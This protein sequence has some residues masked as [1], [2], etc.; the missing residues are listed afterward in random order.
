MDEAKMTSLSEQIARDMREGVFPKQSDSTKAE[1]RARLAYETF[2]S[3]FRVDAPCPVPHW[4]DAP[5]WVRDAVHV[6]YLQGKLD[7]PSIET[8]HIDG[9][10]ALV[11]R[12]EHESMA[13]HRIQRKWLESEIAG[14]LAQ[15]R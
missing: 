12:F 14:L 13:L 11:H 8:T 15:Q 9:A 10:K 3:G 5:A 2:R 4:D 1:D 6:A 7:K